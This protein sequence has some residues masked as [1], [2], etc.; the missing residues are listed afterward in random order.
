M[1]PK[2]GSEE[3]FKK[4]HIRD[5]LPHTAGPPSEQRRS[6]SKVVKLWTFIASI[7]FLHAFDSVSSYDS[8]STEHTF[9][10]LL[11]VLCAAAG[12]PC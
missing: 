4:E 1:Q 7:V 10:S 5:T 6:W 8:K 9:I 2:G 11:L 3:E 12:L